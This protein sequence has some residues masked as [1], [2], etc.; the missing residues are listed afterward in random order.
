LKRPETAH[1]AAAG[2]AGETL[3]IG[4]IVPGF[5]AD[6]SDWCIPAVRNLVRELARRHE[7]HVF[8]LRYPHRRG[9]YRVDGA[10]VHAFGGALARKW[11]RA[12]L[13]ARAF[14]HI[15]DQHRRHPLD[16]L[17]ALWADEPGLL[18]VGAGSL[19]GVP[20][21]VSL[22]GG[23]L[24]GLP[25]L[26]Y[27]GQLSTVNRTM[28]RLAV[29]R[30]NCVTA[31]STYLCELATSRLGCQGVVRLPL[32]VD[33][34][35]FHPE[36]EAG[37]GPV[38]DGGGRNLL[39]VASLTA[40]KD[41]ETLLRAMALVVPRIPGARLH[42]VGEGPL[43]ARLERQARD[44]DISAAVTFHGSVPHDELPAYYRA[45]DLCVLTSRHESQGMVVLEAA[46]CGRATVG[47]AVGILP[48][49]APPAPP[50]PVGDAPGLAGALVALLTDPS[51][52]PELGRLA[53]EAVSRGYTLKGSSAALSSL[54]G[55]VLEG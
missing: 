55:R 33:T 4:M 19:L 2:N 20:S 48:E 26:G 1:V 32:G 18:A 6:E 49:L 43:R 10:A 8:A 34:R 22:M 23:E 24:V 29:G 44:L 39:N 54:Y 50:V 11:P 16:L 17:H 38:L 14:R 25:E 28:T 53:L 51:A 42:V 5:S 40:V 47:T 41:Q 37:K 21:V 36:P 3:R 15:V 52:L 45:A 35:R 27:G 31:G 30:A 13:L 12:K 9:S 46:A 7:V